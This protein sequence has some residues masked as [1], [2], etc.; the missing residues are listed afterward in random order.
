MW[1]QPKIMTMYGGAG[2]FETAIFFEVHIMSSSLQAL[3][4][5]RIFDCLTTY[6]VDQ[7]WFYSDITDNL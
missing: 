1:Q 3:E 6:N 7:C 5:W 2:G 4:L